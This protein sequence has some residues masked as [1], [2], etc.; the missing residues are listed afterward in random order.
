MACA[1]IP[2]LWISSK[3]PVKPG[4]LNKSPWPHALPP[5]ISTTSLCVTLASVCLTTATQG[6]SPFLH[7]PTAEPLHTL[8]PPPPT[9]RGL[10]TPTVQASSAQT[11]WCLD[12]NHKRRVWVYRQ[13][14]VLAWLQPSHL[15]SYSRGAVGPPAS[16]WALTLSLVAETLSSEGCLDNLAGLA[17]HLPAPLWPGVARGLCSADGTWALGLQ[18]VH[19]LVHSTPRAIQAY[20]RC[21]ISIWRREW[22]NQQPVQAHFVLP[23]LADWIECLWRGPESRD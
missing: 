4:V 22:A 5:A 14:T 13:V 2:L 15:G 7:L 6:F 17:S 19:L 11:F 3:G 21:L 1:I 10:L 23:S 8:I 18:S 16:H 20:S 9:L 12:L